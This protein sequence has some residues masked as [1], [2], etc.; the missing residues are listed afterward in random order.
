MN[1][2]Q[3]MDLFSI[4]SI[5][6]IFIACLGLLGLATFIIERKTKEIGI[7]KVLGATIPEIV[8]LLSKEFSKWILIANIIA[9]P[10]AFYAMSNWLKDYAYRININLWVFILSGF[11]A[12]AIAMLTISAHAIKA[13]T[14]NPVKSLRYE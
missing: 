7:R 2:K 1:E 11:I 10:L 8:F 4:F 5:L 3:T 12:L 13:A 9:W 6:A 14:A